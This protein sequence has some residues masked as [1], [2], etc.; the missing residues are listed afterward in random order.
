MLWHSC[1]LAIMLYVFVRY[2][3]FVLSQLMRLPVNQASRSQRCS[4]LTYLHYLIHLY[5]I[6]VKELR[7]KGRGKDQLSE[8]KV[9]DAY[10]KY[11]WL[12]LLD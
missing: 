10:I 11:S 1:D 2:P 12:V 9:I 5:Q 8:F 7:S 4:I 3:R 6:K